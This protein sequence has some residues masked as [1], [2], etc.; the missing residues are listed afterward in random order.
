MDGP[1]NFPPVMQVV[2]VSSCVGLFSFFSCA[3]TWF[4]SRQP[5]L[6]PFSRAWFCFT[7]VAARNLFY[8]SDTFLLH[9]AALSLVVKG[10]R[11]SQV[12][13]ISFFDLNVIQLP[14]H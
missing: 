10:C 1:K 12:P 5:A 4:F 6:S 13:A 7:S 9:W 14:I 11:Q 3:C 8:F 2:Q